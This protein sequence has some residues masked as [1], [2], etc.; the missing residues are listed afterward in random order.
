MKKSGII[1]AFALVMAS[2]A[3]EPEACLTVN[4]DNPKL[5]Q[6]IIASVKREPCLNFFTTYRIS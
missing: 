3:K 6:E 2:C 4:E 5:G 1:L